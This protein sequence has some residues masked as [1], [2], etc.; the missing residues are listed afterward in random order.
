MGMAAP[1]Q[2]LWDWL[3]H[4]RCSDVVYHMTRKWVNPHIEKN[5]M[6]I[7]YCWIYINFILFGKVQIT[8]L[9]VQWVSD[10]VSVFVLL[11][12]IFLSTYILFDGID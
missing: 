4:D 10:T 12:V 1:H 6:L 5:D 8:I 11:P 9:R 2:S 7:C 3:L